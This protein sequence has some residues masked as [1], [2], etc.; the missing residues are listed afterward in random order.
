MRGVAHDMGCTHATCTQSMHSGRT[1]ITYAHLDLLVQEDKLSRR[2]GRA[3]AVALV[4]REL[5]HAD[6]RVATAVAGR[7]A[8]TAHAVAHGQ[9]SVAVAVVIVEHDALDAVL[10]AVLERVL[11]SAAPGAQNEQAAQ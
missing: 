2:L 6:G 5:V 1:W 3:I 4:V 10:R 11:R 9:S 7:I 8:A